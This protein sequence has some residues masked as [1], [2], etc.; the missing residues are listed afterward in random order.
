MKKSKTKEY[1]TDTKERVF[2]Q[3]PIINQEKLWFKNDKKT[4]CTFFF[5][6]TLNVNDQNL[7]Y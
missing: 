7:R 5:P 1:F 4:Y 2:L 3:K 6:F